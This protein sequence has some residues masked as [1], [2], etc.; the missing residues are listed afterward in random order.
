MS[1]APTTL[2]TSHPEGLFYRSIEE[3][4]GASPF[5]F[6]GW[7]P[8]HFG[9]N[10]DADTPNPLIISIHG[11]NHDDRPTILNSPIALQ[12]KEQRQSDGHSNIFSQP[13]TQSSSHLG[14]I[15]LMSSQ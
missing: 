9:N 5:N 4:D 11:N 3:S 15:R 8:P 12:L 1:T 10:T 7:L 13:T 2:P 14:F 6:D